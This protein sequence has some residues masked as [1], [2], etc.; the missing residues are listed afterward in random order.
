MHGCLKFFFINLSRLT[1]IKL[2]YTVTVLKFLCTQAK[3]SNQ[4]V[5]FYFEAA[6]QV[7]Q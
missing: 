7:F 4:P 5:Y 6:E 3:W 2:A 1:K